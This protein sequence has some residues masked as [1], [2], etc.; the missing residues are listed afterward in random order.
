[1]KRI[2]F[3]LLLVVTF[4]AQ[5]VAGGYCARNDGL[6]WRAVNTLYDCTADETY[7]DTQ[8]EI[9][10]IANAIQSITMRQAREQLLAMGLFGTVD[11]TI[12][13]MTGIEG[14]KARITWQ[15]SSE[16]RRDNTLF[17]SIKTVLGLTDA[18]VETFFNDGSKL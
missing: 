12:S 18:Q 16:V 6:G 11:A 4:S 15:Y 5:T 13:S 10:P 9:V 8:P 14:D 1:M 3:A 17:Q 2:L 7:S